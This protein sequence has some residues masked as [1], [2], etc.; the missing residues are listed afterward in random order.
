[1]A[2]GTALF[3]VYA[4]ARCV[5]DQGISLW[6]R[7]VLG[8]AALLLILTGGLTDLIGLAV[9]GLGLGGD[10]LAWFKKIRNGKQKEDALEESP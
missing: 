4:L 1:M 7:A 2:V 6:R 9:L 8:V 10:L 5:I 3:G